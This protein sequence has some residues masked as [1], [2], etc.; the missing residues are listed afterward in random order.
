MFTDTDSWLSQAHQVKN[1]PPVAF[2]HVPKVALAA[3]DKIN[4][5]AEY[6][7]SYTKIQQGPTEPYSHF[8]GRLEESIEKQ[9]RGDQ[10]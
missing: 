1:I 8:I 10:M 3:R 4:R 9:V 7:G 2:P 6:Q 5:G